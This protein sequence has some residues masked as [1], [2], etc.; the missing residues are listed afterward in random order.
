MQRGQPYPKSVQVGRPRPVKRMAFGR[1]TPLSRG[2]APLK[3]SPLAQRSKRRLRSYAGADGRAA[4]VSATLAVR[5]RCEAWSPMCNGR[6]S[7]VHESI[8][9][10]RGGAIVPGP[11]AAAQG[12]RFIVVCS[13]CHAYIHSH[14][15][16]AERRGLLDPRH[17]SQIPKDEA[18][19]IA[20]LPLVSKKEAAR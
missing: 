3:R 5:T 15:P 19:A 17:A 14:R 20:M 9:R 12:Q 13:S 10:S 1:R 18:I 11:L 2:T 16:W 8:L 7:D 6:A 4:F